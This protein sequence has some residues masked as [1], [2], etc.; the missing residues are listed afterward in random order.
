MKKVFALLLFV[1]LLIS[2]CIPAYAVW[3]F[4]KPTPTPAPLPEEQVNV[5]TD[6]Y[7]FFDQASNKYFL[8]FALLDAENN[9]LSP[10]CTADVTLKTNTGEILYQSKR[11]VTSN[12]YKFWPLFIDRSL[13]CAGIQIDASLI[14]PC[15]SGTGTVECHVYKDG[16]FDFDTFILDA[17]NLPKTDPSTL[18]SLQIPTVP[19]ELS[20]YSFG[21][22]RSTIQLNNIIY[23][24]E[25]YFNSENVNLTITLYGEKIF[26]DSKGVT[27]ESFNW[28]LYDSNGYLVDSGTFVI[29]NLSLGDK[30]RKDCIHLY[31]LPADNY[32]LELYDY[33]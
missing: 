33:K 2:A 8:L 20:Y 25:P 26:E 22:L 4:S 13:Y 3:P 1:V 31:N 30:F 19:M 29:D 6:C 18:C 5:L 9:P 14:K 11:S 15:I 12:G 21:T 23:K 7:F 17:L 27:F 10:S 28:K 16:Y 32:R 24:F